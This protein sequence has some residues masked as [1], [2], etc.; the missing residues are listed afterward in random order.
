[1]LTGLVVVSDQLVGRVPLF[2][3]ALPSGFALPL[4]AEGGFILQLKGVGVTLTSQA[5]GALNGV[6]HVSAFAA[7][8]DIGTA[9]VFAIVSSCRK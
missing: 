4:K 9:D 5:A 3:L 7:G 6:Y 8:L 2:N 1:V